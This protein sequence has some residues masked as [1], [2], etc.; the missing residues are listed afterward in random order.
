LGFD[1]KVVKL[2]DVLVADFGIVDIVGSGLR[3]VIV[4]LG[5]R[6]A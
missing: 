5:I 6:P 4:Y 3:I 1:G 2:C